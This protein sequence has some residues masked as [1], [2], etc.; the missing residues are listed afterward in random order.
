MEKFLNKFLLDDYD[1]CNS[2]GFCVFLLLQQVIIS[3]AAI[4]LL[5]IPDITIP[6]EI[7][8]RLKEYKTQ[9]VFKQLDKVAIPNQN[10]VNSP[11][12]DLS[13]TVEPYVFP[14]TDTTTKP[15][16]LP[17]TLKAVPGKPLSAAP[18]TT[19]VRSVKEPTYTWSNSDNTVTVTY[20]DG[21]VEKISKT[22]LTFLMK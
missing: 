7:P 13:F 14:T 8:A 10:T 6:D 21:K 2:D 12:K 1:L 4:V 16:H 17:A 18:A 15:K 22:L 19:V 20:P 9:E 11:V 5:C 3:I